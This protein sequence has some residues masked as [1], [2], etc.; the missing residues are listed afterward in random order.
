MRFSRTLGICAFVA[1]LLIAGW[2][3][4]TAAAEP[5]C[6]AKVTGVLDEL[7]IAQEQRREISVVSR[8]V[9]TRDG[10]F[11]A[12]YDAWVRLTTCSGALIVDLRRDCRVKQ[13]YT[14]GD[15]SVAGVKGF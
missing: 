7:G 3:W 4:Q 12:G 2:S 1:A 6:L 9:T 8:I 14:R 13:T 15:C 10:S 11:V 5:R